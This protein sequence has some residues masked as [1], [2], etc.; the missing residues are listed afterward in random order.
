MERPSCRYW[1]YFHTT[2][3]SS[4]RVVEFL[5]S[6]FI[7]KHNFKGL[8]IVVVNCTRNFS[9]VEYVVE[10]K[11]VIVSSANSDDISDSQNTAHTIYNIQYYIVLWSGKMGDS[12]QV[13]DHG[14]DFFW[15]IILDYSFDK[16]P[17][18]SKRLEHSASLCS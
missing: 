11:P 8:F 17:C 5:L 18:S 7:C 2:L 15:N 14:L 16:F 13:F 9:I 3:L 4:T 10:R 12:K 6:P 1:Y